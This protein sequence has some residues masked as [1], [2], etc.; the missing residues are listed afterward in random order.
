MGQTLNE[1]TEMTNALLSAASCIETNL[2]YP[3]T[4]EEPDIISFPSLCFFTANCKNKELLNP[5]LVTTMSACPSNY[6]HAN[7]MP[8]H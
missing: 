4:E 1:K 7:T 6:D 2:R 3:P 8:L 5:S